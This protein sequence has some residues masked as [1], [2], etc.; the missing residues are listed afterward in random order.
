MM[1]DMPSRL[2]RLVIGCVVLGVGV[3]LLLLA[4][5]GSDG[6]STFVNGTS[7]TIGVPFVLVNVCIGGAFVTVG[8]LRGVRLGVGTVAQ[9]VVVGATVSGVLSVGST[10]D[11][12]LW[13]CLLMVLAFPVLAVG[14]AGYLATGTGA[15]PVEAVALA[16]DPPVPFRWCYT[17]IQT[18]S[19]LIGWV[20]GAAIGVGTVLVMLL[21]GPAVDLLSRWVPGLDITAAR[22]S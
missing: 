22:R 1:D 6:Y 11:Q 21:L 3:G 20:L 4:A 17:T 8:W 10:P 15:G 18:A 12:L 2:V 7:R 5:L 19:A 14:I 13:R 16:F 9:L